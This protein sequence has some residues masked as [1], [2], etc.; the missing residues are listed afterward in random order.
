[1]ESLPKMRRLIAVSGVNVGVGVWVPEVISRVSGV[2]LE[3]NDNKGESC[4]KFLC[5]SFFRRIDVHK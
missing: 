4:T 5:F 1:M 2:V 3:G